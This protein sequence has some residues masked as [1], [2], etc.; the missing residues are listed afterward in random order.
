MAELKVRLQG[1]MQ[2]W[3]V[4]GAGQIRRTHAQPQKRA[5]LGLIRAAKGLSRDEEWADLE[6]LEYRCETLRAGVRMWDFATMS[7]VIS[8]DGK[9]MHPRGIQ[10]KEYL[11]NADFLIHLAGS[12]DLIA[13]VRAALEDPVFLIGLGRRDC[14]PSAP[15]LTDL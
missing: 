3:G 8:A 2:A 9:V 10:E 11:A 12:D 4:D 6:V 5:V 7:N 13:E 15:L 14:P 1:P